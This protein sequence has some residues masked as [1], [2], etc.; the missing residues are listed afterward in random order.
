V[1]FFIHEELNF[2]GA[3]PDAIAVCDCCPRRAVEVKCPYS[4]AQEGKSL[5][6][7][8]YVDN[9]SLQLKENHIYFYQIQLQMLCAGVEF[10]D[11]I[12]WTPNEHLMLRCARNIDL[13]NEMME[14][15]RDYFYNAIMPE[16]LSKYHTRNVIP[17]KKNS[18]NNDNNNEN[19]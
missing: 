6:T 17:K 1:G 8:D 2:L 7:L 16:L 5:W 9:V 19:V 3:T 4:V 13:C 15:T 11:F 14:K 18:K 10:C 12:V